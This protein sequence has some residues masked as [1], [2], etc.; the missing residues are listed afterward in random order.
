[1]KYLNPVGDLFTKGEPICIGRS[2]WDK[3]ELADSV[4]ILKMHP[5]SSLYFSS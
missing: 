5:S 3:F 4:I 1:M 2:T